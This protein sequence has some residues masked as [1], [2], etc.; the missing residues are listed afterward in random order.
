MSESTKRK[1]TISEKWLEIAGQTR[2]EAAR[3]P[4]GRARD[5]LLAKARQLEIALELNEWVTS[6][7]ARIPVGVENFKK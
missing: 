7:G 3:L 1:P 4:F 6:P 2:D 5:A